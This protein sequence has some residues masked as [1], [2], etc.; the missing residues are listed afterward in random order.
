MKSWVLLDSASKTDIFRKY[1]YRT[2]IKTMT[3]TLNLMTNGSL[4]TTNQQG[5]FKN[6]GNRESNF[7]LNFIQNFMNKY[8]VY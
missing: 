5:H 7:M 8:L 4:L 1:K 6:Y 3:T 2:H